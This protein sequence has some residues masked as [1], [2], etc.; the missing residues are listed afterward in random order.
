MAHAPEAEAPDVCDIDGCDYDEV[1][2]GLCGAHYPWQAVTLGP[3]WR[4]GADGKFILPE[5]TLGYECLRWCY[6]YLQHKGKPWQFT[7]EQARLVLWWYA[8]DEDGAFRFSTGVIQRVKGWGKDPMSAALSAFELLG[9]CRFDHFDDSV[10]GGVVGQRPDEPWVQVAGVSRES[11][12]STMK[13]FPGLF[14]KRCVDEYKLIIGRVLIH[15]EG[16][17]SRIEAVTS[18]AAALEGGRPSFLLMGETHRWDTSN[19]G[20]EMAQTG[21]AN[22]GK[23][24]ARSLAITN[25]PQMGRGSVGETDREAYEDILAGRSADIGYFYDS[26]EAPADAPLTPEAI[27]VIL[28]I[29]RGDSIWLNIKRTMQ[30]ILNP[31]F[32][33]ARSRRFYYNQ[34][35]ATSDV[36][37]T[38]PEWE[39]CRVEPDPLKPG[40]EIV[41][42]L[43]GGK[44]DDATA[45][46]AI[47]LRDKYIQPLGVWEPSQN[48]NDDLPTETDYELV[49]GHIAQAFS[50]YKVRAFFSDVH[51]IENY[52]NRWS[53]EYREELLIKAAP[54][55]SAVGFDMRGNQ[56]EIVRANEMLVG[57]IRGKEVRWGAPAAREAR[58][59]LVTK[60]KQHVLNCFQ[61]PHPSGYG[62]SFGKESRESKRK[63]DGYA[64]MLLAFIAMNKYLESGRKPA[65]PKKT[66]G[67]IW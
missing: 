5:K 12:K 46:I 56:R 33:A 35:V 42:G 6:K 62:M 27:P 3:S 20:H 23:V 61:R 2:D 48:E 57:C 16:G 32:P 24:D 55:K 52:V 31:A 60:L 26:L 28:A 4:K 43:D 15:A 39:G 21:R 63:V 14:T 34:L 66:R 8:V 53:D 40:D 51:P 7:P 9:N 17:R 37:V 54:G 65:E 67:W 29:V 49:S 10:P 22:A 1:K 58:D 25:A 19:G 41:L 59:S 30:E 11:T 13:I 50:L 64:A 44:T 47:R 38:D 45:L 18:S 36:L